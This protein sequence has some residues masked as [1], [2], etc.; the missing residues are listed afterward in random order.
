[1]V[2]LTCELKV[3]SKAFGTIFPLK[4]QVKTSE[5]F[6][7]KTQNRI[8]CNVQ[9]HSLIL[10]ELKAL[11]KLTKI[12]FFL[13]YYMAMFFTAMVAIILIRVQSFNIS[14]VIMLVKSSTLWL[15]VTC[16]VIWRPRL[17][18]W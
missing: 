7:I 11:E 4:S 2:E 14:M 18:K 3:V 8:K 12:S 1:M 13:V 9:Y 10:K 5:S 15:N 16:F 6:W 17:I